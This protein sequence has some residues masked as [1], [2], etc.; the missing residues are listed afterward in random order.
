MA[1]TPSGMQYPLMRN[2]YG[3]VVPIR[4]FFD[5][6]DLAQQAFRNNEL[7]PQL[8]RMN[9]PTGTRPLTIS[10]QQ[11][12]EQQFAPTEQQRAIF[13]A[14]SDIALKA[15]ESQMTYHGLE[16]GIF[17]P[18]AKRLMGD[19]D[20]SPDIEI[21][22]RY[23]VE[24]GVVDADDPDILRKVSSALRTNMEV[25]D[26]NVAQQRKEY[27]GRNLTDEEQFKCVS[28]GLSPKAVAAVAKYVEGGYDFNA[29]F[30]MMDKMTWAKWARDSRKFLSFDNLFSMG[31]EMLTDPLTYL[32]YGVA[33]KFPTLIARAMSR[34]ALSR[35]G[36]KTLRN[37]G[38]GSFVSG[39]AGFSY[40]QIRNYQGIDEDVWGI[41]A[42]AAAFGGALGFLGG[43]GKRANALGGE[44]VEKIAITIGDASNDAKIMDGIHQEVKK[45]P[46]VGQQSLGAMV[47]EESFALGEQAKIKEL[48]KAEED[49]FFG[50][51]LYNKAT[52][53]DVSNHYKLLDDYKKQLQDIDDNV[54][55]LQEAD[56]QMVAEALEYAENKADAVK[57]GSSRFLSEHEFA[58]DADFTTAQKY[59]RR[60]TSWIPNWTLAGALDFHPSSLVQKWNSM[61]K[62]NEQGFT[63][64]NKA[65]GKLVNVRSADTNFIDTMMVVKERGYV[66]LTDFINKAA[67]HADNIGVPVQEI[68]DKFARFMRTHHKMRVQLSDAD[69]KV[70]EPLLSMFRDFREMSLD[71]SRVVGIPERITTNAKGELQSIPIDPL[72]EKLPEGYYFPSIIDPEKLRKIK[73]VELEKIKGWDSPDAE[74]SGK[75]HDMATNNIIK[76]VEDNLYKGTR[77]NETLLKV[78]DADRDADDAF[79]LSK[80]KNYKSEVQVAIN[81]AD[82][83]YEKIAK[84]TDE[85]KEA[86]AKGR[87]TKGKEKDLAKAEKTLADLGVGDI[88]LGNTYKEQVYRKVRDQQLRERA[89]AR[90]VGTVNQNY[91]HNTGWDSQHGFGGVD[92]TEHRGDWWDDYFKN[93][94]SESSLADLTDTFIPRVSQGYI[95]QQS[96]KLSANQI[97]GAKSFSDVKAWQADWENNFFKSRKTTGKM[98]KKD[99]QTLQAQRGIIMGGFG[100]S[101]KGGNH[102]GGNYINATA[103]EGVL[104]SIKLFT[105]TTKNG[106]FALYN[107]FESGSLLHAEGAMAWLKGLPILRTMINKNLIGSA[108]DADMRL[109]RGLMFSDEL[110][111]TRSWNQLRKERAGKY[112]DD[113]VL[114]KVV[115]GL[116][117]AY[118]NSPLTRFQSHTQ[119]TP[120]MMAAEYLLS[121]IVQY[122]HSGIIPKKGYAKGFFNQADFPRMGIR[123]DE[124]DRLVTGL[125]NATYMENGVP[126]VRPDELEKILTPA[127]R[128]VLHRMTSY[129]R[130][131]AIQGRSF[132]DNPLYA[133]GQFSPFWDI[134]FQFRS[135]AMQSFR[136]KLL[137]QGNRIAYEGAA[138]EAAIQM[139]VNI[140][141]GVNM[142][143]FKTIVRAQTIM[144]AEDRENYLMST[145]GVKGLSDVD[146]SDS[147]I[148]ATLFKNGFMESS[149]FAGFSWAASL[150]SSS[151]A[152]R[153]TSGQDVSFAKPVKGAPQVQSVQWMLSRNI[154]VIGKANEIIRSF[155]TITK[156]GMQPSKFRDV[157]TAYKD[158]TKIL[159]TFIPNDPLSGA[160]LRGFY[161]IVKNPD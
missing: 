102:L 126:R 24:K 140:A 121:D 107:P 115:T 125:K 152:M 82:V 25:K 5:L 72:M 149:W 110:G 3:N 133:G 43:L 68:Y 150:M 122:A 11:E 9:M 92:H 86:K 57:T 33:L 85:I 147:T 8:S 99:Q 154:P 21:M 111:Y 143:M 109:F 77:D 81:K 32:P 10:S 54:A 74:I 46:W 103:A 71:Q 20:V 90:A 50:L 58:T 56:R 75:A 137:K 18:V 89:N 40:A 62:P 119:R 31:A 1:D 79:K 73:Q 15:I 67:E 17:Y 37:V 45:T 139:G 19:L 60:F 100:M 39:G 64:K 13:S 69:A 44:S 108:S 65:T 7:H 42:A 2:D 106:F 104:E 130:D 141:M 48:I 129:V 157:N 127:N 138:G 151:A 84:L 52:P 142:T 88:K 53:E 95:D 128:D 131:E 161:E 41:T 27:Y 145:L 112:G 94:E 144:D 28:A 38:G 34:G 49:R 105:A 23:C 70:I 36:L 117:Y 93:H 155:N 136:K 61:W 35:V 91:E 98:S 101:N 124:L 97:I 123:S 26:F 114:G 51:E 132:I 12:R 22:K 66:P 120:E 63:M 160:A 113:S 59:W 14:Q 156:Y 153:N 116:D 4:D 47:A 76:Q 80:N 118:R 158:M 135:F 146:L 96:A 159:K 29:S 55:K 30:E 148:W 87:G 6:D 83:A 16:T 78:F 134:F